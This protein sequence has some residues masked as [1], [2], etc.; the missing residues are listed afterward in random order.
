VT[1]HTPA[2]ATQTP[3]APPIED[4]ENALGEAVDGLW[5]YVDDATL[6]DELAECARYHRRR[7][8]VHDWLGRN[9]RLAS[10]TRDDLVQGFPGS[11]DDLEC[12]RRGGASAVAYGLA[13]VAT[14]YEG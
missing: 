12:F 7:A 2:T 11:F 4:V 1:E 14:E 8:E 3:P 13:D 10:L 9:P 5:S 6:G